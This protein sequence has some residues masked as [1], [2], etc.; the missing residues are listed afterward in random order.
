M[1]Q[2]GRSNMNTQDTNAELTMKEA[3]RRLSDTQAMLQLVLDTIPVR[4][5]WKNTD[6]KYVGCN[7]GFARDAGFNS[8]DE[9]AGKTDF[10]L[11]WA[12]TLA[13]QYRADDL[14]V[15]KTG[16]ARMGYEEPL[17][18][19]DG[20]N[21]WVRTSKAPLRDS[22]GKI[23]GV[24]GTYE[25][26]TEHKLQD[27][28]LVLAES[29]LRATL[30]GIGDAVISTDSEGN[31]ALM[32]PVAEHLT[33]WRE[34]EARG[35]RLSEVFHIINEKTR[36]RIENPFERVLK[37]G[38]IVGLANHTLLVA[39]DGT[40]RPIGDSGAPIIGKGNRVCGAVIIFRDLTNER[41]AMRDLSESEG[42]FKSL[43]A[44]SI[45]AVVLMEIVPNS[46][47]GPEDCVFIEANAALE[48]HIGIRPQELAGK[49]MRQLLPPVEHARI[50][51][52]VGKLMAAGESS[53]FEYFFKPLKRHFDVSGYRI[54]PNRLACVFQ[55][56]TERKEAE[57]ALRASLREKDFLLRE[58]HH[59]VKNNM[60]VVSSLLQ[61]QS[62]QIQDPV[63]KRHFS[64]ARDRIRS[65]ALVHEKLYKKE[66]IAAIEFSSYAKDLVAQLFRSYGVTENRIRL[67][68]DCNEVFLGPDDAIPLGLILN[69]LVSNALKH[70]FPGGRS[71]AIAINFETRKSTLLIEV[72]DDGIGLPAGFNLSSGQTLGFQIINALARQLNGGI[73]VKNDKGAH[74][75]IS[76]KRRS[77][78]SRNTPP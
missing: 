47:G 11:A 74:F 41:K 67:R 2:G 15:I 51:K 10:Q 32:N 48:K 36:R 14:E 6:L 59:R 64:E 77:A 42:R 75:V 24:I 72:S 46:T 33:G 57:E 1:Q 13:A 44:N 43:F 27:Q 18:L 39:R 63:V 34:S 28:K 16:R 21:L 23:I 66:N 78:P 20:R 7:M 4:V 29:E 71:G 65:M 22:G 68:L 69:E 5:F 53:G 19:A 8:P 70:A 40:E 17:T 62:D 54:G 9:L 52:M 60:Q 35:R 38:V 30:Y 55:D 25:D 37:K 76:I 58:I 12:S 61:L 26:I 49:R 50:M 45:N 56:V 3:V 73:R 31:V